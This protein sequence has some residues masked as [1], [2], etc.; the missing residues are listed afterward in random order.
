MFYYLFNVRDAS[1]EIVGW[2]T[3][4]RDISERKRA[5]EAMLESRQAAL[6]LMTDAIEARDRSEQMGQTLRASE[7][8]IR[9]LNRTLEQRVQERTAELRAANQELDAFAYAVSH[10][11]RQPLRAMNGFSRALLEDQGTTLPGAAHEY[12]DEIILASRRMGDLIDGVLRLSRC[13]RGELRRD[14]VAISEL[15]TRILGELVKAEPERHVS[16]TVA[17]GLTA[18]GDERMLEVVLSNLLGNAWKYTANRTDAVIEVG[19]Q[20]SGKPPEP[21]TPNPADGF[22]VFF[23][24]DNGAGFDMK[25]AAKLFQPFQRLHRENE[26][27]GLGIGLATVQRIVNRHGGSI[28]AAAGPE[29]GATFYFSLP[30]LNVNDE[31]KL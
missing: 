23:V 1:G 25:H 7:E 9:E 30:V 10:D 11:L 29:Q 31:E 13:T 24:R 26:F 8:E 20:G 12:L 6:N 19:V 2:A 3:V 14:A 22:A 15:A 17:P 16:W 18:L 27:P 21:Q 5:E 28:Q 4:S